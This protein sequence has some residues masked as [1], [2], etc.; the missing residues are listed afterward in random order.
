[1]LRNRLSQQV[2]VEFIERTTDVKF[3]YPVVLPE[4]LAGIGYRIHR[5]FIKLIPV[6]VRVKGP[7]EVSSDSRDHYLLCDPISNCGHS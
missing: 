7:K 5:R 2:P 4:S 3:D 6:R 1:M